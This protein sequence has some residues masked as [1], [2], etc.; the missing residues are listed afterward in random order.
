V[1][2]SNI[3]QTVSILRATV[4]QFE[5]IFI[6]N[7]IMRRINNAKGMRM[8]SS[9]TSNSDKYDILILLGYTRNRIQNTKMK[10]KSI[11]TKLKGTS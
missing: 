7:S 10:F 6:I 3:N 9:Q 5:P 8:S 11:N 4:G 1:S 2:I